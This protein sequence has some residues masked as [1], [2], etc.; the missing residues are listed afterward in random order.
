MAAQL[1]A[2]E[3]AAAEQE[4]EKLTAAE[5]SLFIANIVK[6]VTLM[7]NNNT[8]SIT[9]IAVNMQYYM[10]TTGV[11]K[12]VSPRC[13]RG[14]ADAI[15]THTTLTIFP[16]SCTSHTTISMHTP[17]NTLPIT[18]RCGCDQGDMDFFLPV[19]GGTYYSPTH[20]THLHTQHT[21]YTH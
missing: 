19:S 11:N 2:E 1:A 12:L 14:L 4:A 18:P 6:N 15:T 13:G 10:S 20:C 8:C 16:L 7:C 3:L 17:I 5:K 9:E 21:H